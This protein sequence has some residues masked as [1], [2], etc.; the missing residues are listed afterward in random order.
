M[1]DF[2]MPFCYNKPKLYKGWDIMNFE[3]LKKYIDALPTVYDVKSCDVSVRYKHKEVFRHSIGFSDLDCTK[4]TTPTDLQ[5]V[6]SMTKVITTT[7]VMRLIIRG[8]L[9]MNDKV[10]KYLPEYENLTVKTADGIKPATKP[11]L[12]WHLFAMRSGMN[13]NLSAPS[14]KEAL[15][16]GKLSTRELVAAMA[17]EPLGFEP[18]DSYCYSLSHDVLAAVAE[19]VSGKSYYEFLCDELFIPLGMKDTGFKPTDEQKKRFTTMW[20]FDP[21]RFVCKPMECKCVY[22]LSPEYESG[23]AGLFTTVDDYMK[24]IDAL[25]N[26][27]IAENGYEVLSK[28]GIAKLTEVTSKDDEILGGGKH[29]YKYGHGVRVMVKP[30]FPGEESLSPVGEF[31]WDGAAAA[32]NL[33][34]PINN[35]AIVFMTQTHSFGKSYVEIQPQIRNRVYMSL[36]L[37]KK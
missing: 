15:A 5:W 1:V 4:P 25:A 37:D 7:A 16:N 8:E 11:L 19:V 33:I 34:D 12:V 24:V 31:G 28:E 3:G 30:D 35:I 6:Y 20:L 13:Y 22:N 21:K 29:A 32:Y 17:K 10:S 14:I 23:G 27:G 26:G 2:K 36:G 18:G 9:Q